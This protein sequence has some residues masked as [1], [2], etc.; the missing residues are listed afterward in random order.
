MPSSLHYRQATIDDFDALK[1]LGILAYQGFQAILAPAEWQKMSDFLHN[2]ALIKDLLLQST[3]FGAIA[4]GQLVGMAYLV[5]SG[6]P[7]P[8]YQA[9]WAAVRLVGVHPDYRGKGISKKMV[10]QCMEYARKAGETT[11]ALHTGEYMQPAPRIY[12]SLGFARFREIGLI[13]G[14]EYAVYTLDLRESSI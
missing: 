1:T 11:I 7:T 6:N 8:I 13:Y 12:E 4:D 5:P 14:Q 2:D 9:D 3:I 10:A